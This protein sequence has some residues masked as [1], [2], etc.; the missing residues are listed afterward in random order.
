MYSQDFNALAARMAA[1]LQDVRVCLLLSSDGLTLGAFPESSE[2][3]GRQ[4][5]DAVQAVGDP[6]RGFL[7]LGE[8]IWVMARRGAYAA[9]IVT[10]PT[11]RPGLLLDKLDFMLRQ[12][13]EARLR[14]EAETGA[15]T[16]KP[17]SHRRPRSPLHRPEPSKPEPSLPA[18]LRPPERERVAAEALEAEVSPEGPAEELAG[19]SERIIDVTA[20]RPGVESSA[21]PVLEPPTIRP[22]P[23]A[24]P[25]P[26]PQPR[27]PVRVPPAPPAPPPILPAPGAPPAPGPLVEPEAPA[28]EPQPEPVPGP[29]PEPEPIPERQPEVEPEPEAFV[30]VEEDAV[31]ETRVHEEVEAEEAPDPVAELRALLTEAP[32]AAAPAP[33]EPIEA[34]VF[35]PGVEPLAH[36]E[37]PGPSEGE[38]RSEGSEEVSARTGQVE[39]D[40][41]EQEGEQEERAEIDRVALTREFG[42][43]FSDGGP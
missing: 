35:P 12:A 32:T 40:R 23:P 10:A 39:P 43:L 24:Q 26:G 41:A 30:P 8:E 28:P 15:P 11:V 36:E 34:L 21:A 6:H 1:G 9:V 14:V 5:W 38:G 3:K 16:Q 22:T 37:H 18:A 42:K 33:D 4:V 7:D 19:L 25:A 27:A 20:A 2:E 29:E 13:E 31:P 17:E